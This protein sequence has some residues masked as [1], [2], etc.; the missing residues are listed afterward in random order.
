[1]RKHYHFVET[2]K[3]SR[4]TSHLAERSHELETIIK[5]LIVND[6]THP[7]CLTRFRLGTEFAAQPTERGALQ[8][9]V[10]SDVPFVITRQDFSEFEAA[11]MILQI[12]Q[13]SEDA[14]LHVF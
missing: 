4:V 6:A 9:V 8:L 11:D 12:A 10:V 14:F 2:D 13:I 1:M 7:E 5:G 3:Q